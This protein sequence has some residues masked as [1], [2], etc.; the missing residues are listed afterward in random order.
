MYTE[1]F[2]LLSAV[3]FLSHP[4]SFFTQTALRFASVQWI[5]LSVMDMFWIDFADRAA[6]DAYLA[7]AEHQAIGAEIVAR[8]DGGAEG[9]FVCDLEI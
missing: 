2:R 1:S 6:R 3:S 7:D 4:V 5:G 9:V 8:L